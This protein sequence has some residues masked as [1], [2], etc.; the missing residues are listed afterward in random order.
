MIIE[1]P[2][3]RQRK[4]GFTLVEA[5][6]SVAIIGLVFT[7]VYSFV[8][9]GSKN[10]TSSV[11]HSERLK[12]SQIL[13][14]L[15]HDDLRKASDKITINYTT[16][17]PG[18][19]YSVTPSRFMFL[20]GTD[21]FSDVATKFVNP[22]TNAIG[23]HQVIKGDVSDR[24]IAAYQINRV[25]KTAGATSSIAGYSISV[26]LNLDK[27]SLN[28]SKKLTSGALTADDDEPF[29]GPGKSEAGMTV[30]KDVE[31]IYINAQPIKSELDG[32]DVGSLVHFVIF[33][34]STAEPDR[35]AFFKQSIKTSILSQSCSSL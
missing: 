35:N 9:Q 32:T 26:K 4:C 5:M 1:K 8:H 13:F 15:L 10:V 3:Q 29:L 17:T 14:K 30:M 16:S 6:V 24:T 28:Y 2:R 21:T 23:N 11:W 19:E 7:A 31:F 34:R 12:E 33:V 25:T 20:G 27:K 22:V 18:S